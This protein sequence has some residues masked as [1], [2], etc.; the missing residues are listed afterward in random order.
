MKSS[1]FQ[2]LQLIITKEKN[3][4]KFCNKY[5]IEINVSVNMGLLLCTCG[6]F[7]RMT[8]WDASVVILIADNVDHVLAF[9]RYRGKE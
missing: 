1:N 5:I 4:I 7:K 6:A 2:Y 3:L 8:M 9:K